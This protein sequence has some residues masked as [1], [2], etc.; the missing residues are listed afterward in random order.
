MKHLNIILTF[1][2]VT[3]MSV[4]YGQEEEAKVL[5]VPEGDSTQ[6]IS[7][8]IS[9]VNIVTSK[10]LGCHSP[11]G[12][13]DKAKDAL[14]WEKLQHMSG[15]EAYAVLDEILEVVVEGDMPP[16]KIVE[17]Y[18]N[19]KLSQEESD[20]IADWAEQMLAKLEE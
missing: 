20:A 13:S 19:L 10:C 5:L 9:I 16:E 4:V 18:P 3:M 12:R 14:Q 7:Y 2:A 8:P 17:K 6:V 11:S 1:L 15:T